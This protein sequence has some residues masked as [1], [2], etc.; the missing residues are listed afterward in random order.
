MRPHRVVLGFMFSQLL[1]QESDSW[2]C[3]HPIFCKPG[4]AGILHTVQM[5]GIFKVWSH[6][7]MLTLA[8]NFLLLQDYKV[9][10]D[11]PLLHPVEDILK[12]F[13]T[14]PDRN[15]V[16][17]NTEVRRS[18]I[19]IIFK[20]YN[21]KF[22][23]RKFLGRGDWAWDSHSWGLERKPSFYNKYKRWQFQKVGYQ[24]E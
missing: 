19:Q 12:K 18:K 3:E 22:C 13:E 23:S 7:F 21:I 16:I 4:E 11:K 20:G 6:L 1:A 8:F 5:A 2:P 15:K 24:D 10:V 9:F 17:I 14:L